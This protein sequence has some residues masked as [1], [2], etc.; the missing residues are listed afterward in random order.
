MI[1]SPLQGAPLF[2]LQN[3]DEHHQLDKSKMMVK[4]YV[5]KEEQN[6]LPTIKTVSTK[7]NTE[8]NAREQRPSTPP[9]I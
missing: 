1:S 2:R 3:Q 5:R 6:P 4:L 7:A 8:D 9:Q